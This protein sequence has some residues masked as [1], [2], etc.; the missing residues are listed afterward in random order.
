MF[1]EEVGGFETRGILEKFLY[2]DAYMNIKI[3]F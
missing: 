3:F 1:G 2:R